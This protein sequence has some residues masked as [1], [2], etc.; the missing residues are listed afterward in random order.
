LA[1]D[2][3]YIISSS[4]HYKTDEDTRSIMLDV[5]IALLPV[6]AVSVYFFGWRALVL[7]VVSVASCVAAEFLYQKLMKKPVTIYDLS[8]VV[9]G[10]LLAYNVSVS[11]PYWL[12]AVGGAF[13]IIIVKQLYGGIGKNFMNPALAARVFLLVSWPTLMTNWPAPF[14]KPVLW[15]AVD[16]V[17][18]ATPMSY[19][20]ND[21]LPLPEDVSL[22]QLFIGQNGGCLGETSALLLLLGGLYLLVRRVI[23]VRIPL[24]FI[25]TVALLSYLWPPV[26]V[27]SLNW[28]LYQILS[29]GLILGAVFM[30][31]DYSTSPVTPR[32]QWI[33][34]IGCGLITVLIRSFGTYPEG[35]SFSI[36]IMN[37]CVWLIDKAGRRRRFGVKRFA[38]IGA[39]RAKAGVSK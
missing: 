3:L 15:G 34:G 11:V 6:L 22:F 33:Y 38:R 30:A 21:A 36:L 35:V 18:A 26:G 9:T 27:A 14:S 13:A 23:S 7:T 28:M 24:A 19:L 1:N 32:G 20:K 39:K 37:A 10:I 4:P 16:A 12:V 8:A 25:G 5:I 29:G 17:T 31:T 2:P